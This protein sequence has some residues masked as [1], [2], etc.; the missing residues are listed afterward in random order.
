VGRV[1]HKDALHQLLDEAYEVDTAEKLAV[2]SKC[3][4]R[5]R[6]WT[7][8]QLSARIGSGNDRLEFTEGVLSDG[9]QYQIEISVFWDDRSHGD[10]R[11]VGDITTLPQTVLPGGGYMP[12]ACESF[13]MKPDG[14]FVDE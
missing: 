13:I 8:S 9:T 5:F 12:N 14:S 10:I 2:L 4:G 6:D 1:G 7:H 3:L 11:V